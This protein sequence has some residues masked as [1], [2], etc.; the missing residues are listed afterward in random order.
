MSW[1]LHMRGHFCQACGKEVVPK[2]T[3]Y[4]EAIMFGGRAIPERVAEEQ[5]AYD[6]EEELDAFFDSAEFEERTMG[7]VKRNMELDNAGNL[8]PVAPPDDA[9]SRKV[10][11]EAIKE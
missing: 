1:H 6:P 8:A 2:G 10:L 9:H 3:A 5:L 11:A 4:E 7:A